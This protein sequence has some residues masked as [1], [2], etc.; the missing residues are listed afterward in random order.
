MLKEC[1]GRQ[2]QPQGQPWVTSILALKQLVLVGKYSNNW[3]L[4][5]PAVSRISS[6]HCWPSTS[7]CLRYE[8]SMVGSYFSTK[9]PWTNWTVSADL[10]TPPL[11]STT[12]L[13]SRILMVSLWPNNTQISDGESTPTSC[14]SQTRLGW[15]N[16]RFL[17]VATNRKIG[18]WAV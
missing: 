14:G 9:M 13:Y 10:P 15:L 11:P 2:G 16:W 8:S 18:A 17:R 7:T 12:I 4:T 3:W 6:M 5:V 1:K